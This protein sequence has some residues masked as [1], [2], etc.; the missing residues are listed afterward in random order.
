MS[1]FE[2]VLRYSADKAQ[3]KA[4]KAMQAY[5]NKMVNISNAI[6]QNALTT[7]TT[8][9]IQQSARRS[10]FQKRDALSVMGKTVVASAAAGVRGNS[11]NK[12]LVAVQRGAGLQEKQR[13]DDLSNFFLQVDQQRLSSTLSAVQNQDLTA[14]PKPSLSSY[15]FQDLYS[16]AK[17]A[18]GFMGG[19]PST[20][21]TGTRAPRIDYSSGG[22][23][24]T[25]FPQSNTNITWR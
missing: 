14:I 6:N 18:A 23:D 25:Y 16:N 7:N 8:L 1:I 9:Q 3:Y 19:V 4:A 24:R 10:V 22:R 12:S 20:G 13:Q 21:G 15:I 2:S 5:R 17:K 11:V